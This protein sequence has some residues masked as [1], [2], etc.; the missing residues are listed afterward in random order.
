MFN[1]I[2]I[3]GNLTR[4]VELRHLPSS[5]ALATLG[6]ASNRTYTKQD[7]TKADETCFVDVKLFGRTA[8]VASQY[9][10]KGSKVLIEGRLVYETWSDQN[11]QKRSKHSIVAETMKMLDSKNAS[12]G[13]GG[14]SYDESY[15]RESNYANN[16]GGDSYGANGYGS[17]PSGGNNSNYGGSNYNQSNKN[18]QNPQPKPQQDNIPSIDIDDD[19]IPF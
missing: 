8:E 19:D 17:N 9:L 11:G 15:G 14:D 1:K 13:Y 6:V 16:Y 10:R 3:V 7:G 5:T 18:Y 4:D 12:G 2:I